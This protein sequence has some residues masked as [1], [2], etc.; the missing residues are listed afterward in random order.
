MSTSCEPNL[1]ILK[2]LLL[3]THH[4]AAICDLLIYI[5]NVAYGSDVISEMKAV[6]A[7]HTANLALDLK[8]YSAAAGE[9]FCAIGNG[10]DYYTPGSSAEFTTFAYYASGYDNY[11]E[12]IEDLEGAVVEYTMDLGKTFRIYNVTLFFGTGM[13]NTKANAVILRVTRLV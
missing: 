9:E 5:G 13:A 12:D 1:V 7:N 4:H 8:H 2:R 10:T 6:V 11:T 3:C